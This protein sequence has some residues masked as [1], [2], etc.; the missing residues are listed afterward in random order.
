MCSR[1][2]RVSLYAMTRLLLV[3][4]LVAR[5]LLAA[6]EAPEEPEGVPGLPAIRGLE[7]K[8]HFDA[9]IGAFGFANS[10]YENP[11]PDSPSGNLTDNWFESAVKPGISA[12]WTA[13]GSWQ[14]YGKL[15]A[16][17]ERSVGT[18]PTL[19]GDS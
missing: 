10:L 3:L 13:A 12:V 6:E 15:S 9:T 7:W 17:G 8:F 1:G 14:V 11:L 5:P 16:A 2:P 19:V 4:A 18:P